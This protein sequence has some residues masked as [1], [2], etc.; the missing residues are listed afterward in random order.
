MPQIVASTDS[1]LKSTTLLPRQRC[2]ASSPHTFTN[3]D[4]DRVAP[5]GG[6]RRGHDQ[7]FHKAVAPVNLA[8]NPENRCSVRLFRTAIARAFLCPTS[9]T[10]FLPRVIPV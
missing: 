7:S 5:H 1:Q 9:T 10:N 4:L 6:G 8:S 2:G 3:D